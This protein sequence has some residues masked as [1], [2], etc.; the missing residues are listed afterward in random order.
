MSIYKLAVVADIKE[1]QKKAH[2][3]SSY[4]SI[5]KR[6]PPA[7]PPP[8][9][10]PDTT[11]LLLL[12][13]LDSLPDILDLVDPEPP[14]PDVPDLLPGDDLQ[15]S[16]EQP[17]IAQVREEVVHVETNL[18]REGKG[19]NDNSSR[20]GHSSTAPMGVTTPCSLISTYINHGYGTS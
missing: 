10:F 7:P 4:V 18:R 8:L 2:M 5:I 11:H 19:V 12:Q 14:A 15:E 1:A 3:C 16:D 6:A 13:K 20:G 17:S 9:H